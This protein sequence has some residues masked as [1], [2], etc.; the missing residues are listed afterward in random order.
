[1]NWLAYEH[2][3]YAALAVVGTLFAV[4]LV[5]RLMQRHETR[6][7][8][9]AGVVPPFINIIG[10]LF[11]L[12][13]AFIGNDTWSARDRAMD[14][15]FREA[16]GLRVLLALAD[17]P[18]DA[19]VRAYGHAVA[20]E[21]PRLRAR[22][23]DPAVTTAADTLLRA[24]AEPAVA[25]RF[26]DNVQ[27]MMLEKVVEIRAERDLR[28]SLTQT[29]LNP[30]KWMGMAFLGLVT[31]LSVAAVHIGHPRAAMLAVWLF[32][33]AAAPSAAIVLVQG[34]PFQIPAAVGPEPI[35]AALR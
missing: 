23:S 31:I 35:L 2:Y 20:G 10:V 33:L 16:D 27:Q 7:A 13:L 19:D 34:N 11:G 17:E 18:L 30:L 22:Q 12:T 8:P 3:T 4:W 1:M 26:G 5:G 14:A 32:A 24:V 15:V 29:H 9:F 25:A 6:L 21:W 28:I